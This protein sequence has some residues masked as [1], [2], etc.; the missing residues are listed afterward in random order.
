ME[1]GVMICQNCGKEI[2][3]DSL[4]CPE[5]GTKCEKQ[6]LVRE[7]PVTTQ[8]IKVQLSPEEEAQLKKRN[9]I[10]ALAAAAFVAVCVVVVLLSLLIKPS[11]NLNKYVTISVEGYNNS[12]EA[13]ME[14]DFDKFEE[15]YEEKLGAASYFIYYAIDGEFDKAYDLSNGDVI[16]YKWDCDDDFALE[17]YGMKLK[18][19]DI[20]YKVKNL[21]E[22]V[23]DTQ[24]E[25]DTTA[26]DVKETQAPTE[27]T[28]QANIPTK[29]ASQIQYTGMEGT[30]QE[31]LEQNFEFISYYQVGM[32]NYGSYDNNLKLYVVEDSRVSTWGDFKQIVYSIYSSKRAKEII[33]TDNKYWGPYGDSADL[34]VYPA[35]F[36][37]KSYSV[38]WDNYTIEINSQS[39]SL[40]KFTVTDVNS[41]YSTTGS[42]VQESSGKWL[43]ESE[44]Y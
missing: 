17:M 4:F 8:P 6:K 24:E 40:C 35:N 13:V 44:V 5:C 33:E 14:F 28:T 10:I 3:N 12:G 37:T 9:K 41:G 26:T 39:S 30:I 21:K 43:L 25:A 29:P 32:L 2:P 15:D 31:L 22:A 23:L 34:Y 19:S 16:T 18:Y 42:A 1:D 36:S 7:K 20:K 11:I 27:A 38:T